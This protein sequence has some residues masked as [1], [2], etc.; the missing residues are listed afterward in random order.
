MICVCVCVSGEGVGGGNFDQITLLTLRN[1]R[2]RP[3]QTV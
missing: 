3:E 1:R 2:D